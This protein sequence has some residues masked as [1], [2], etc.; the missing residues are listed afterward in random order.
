MAANHSFWRLGRNDDWGGDGGDDDR[1]ETS[2]EDSLMGTN[3]IRMQQGAFINLPRYSES[4]NQC[5]DRYT[6]KEHGQG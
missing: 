3:Q 6:C 2:G 1:V 4:P 5:G